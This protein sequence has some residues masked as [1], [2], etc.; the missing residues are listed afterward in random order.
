MCVIFYFSNYFLDHAE[1]EDPT[2]GVQEKVIK[3][4]IYFLNLY[5]AFFEGI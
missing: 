5:L 1:E 2:V 3:V 4:L